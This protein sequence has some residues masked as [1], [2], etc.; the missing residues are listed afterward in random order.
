MKKAP[1]KKNMFLCALFE[2]MYVQ[3]ADVFDDQQIVQ[4]LIFRGN[5]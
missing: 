2:A 1:L 3:G 5:L 4:I